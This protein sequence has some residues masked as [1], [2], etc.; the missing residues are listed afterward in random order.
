[1]IIVPQHRSHPTPRS[2]ALA[3]RLRTT[4][5]EFKHREPKVSD[6]EVLQALRDAAPTSRGELHRRKAALVAVLAGVT[7]AIGLG[8]LASNASNAG[9]PIPATPLVAVA[10]VGLG[11]IAAIILRANNDQ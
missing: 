9:R 7:T 6:E 3:E 2:R 5:N 8:L 1:M 4:I 11:L 10:V